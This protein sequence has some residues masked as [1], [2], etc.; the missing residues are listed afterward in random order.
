MFAELYEHFKD[1][2]LRQN[3]DGRYK[4]HSLHTSCAIIRLFGIINLSMGI[5]AL[6][7]YINLWTVNTSYSK[8]INKEI[9]LKKGKYNL[10]I[11]I[12]ELYQNN[13]H[14]TR[15][16]SY[17]QLAGKTKAINL[18]DTEPY[19]YKDGKPYYPAGLIAKTYFKDEIEIEKLKIK[20]EKISWAQDRKLI[21]ITKYTP[22]SIAYPDNWLPTTNRGTKALNTRDEKEMPILNE[23]FINW[24]RLS[25]Y[26]RFRK[27]WGRVEVPKSGKYRLKV[28]S[29]YGLSK[30]QL[31]FTEQCWLGYRNYPLVAG[32]LI[33]GMLGLILPKLLYS[34]QDRS[35]VTRYHGRDYTL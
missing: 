21:G 1:Q 14:Y 22:N 4:S 26:S 13:L 35:P 3:V 9:Y 18:K 32:L 15:S 24:I 7:S 6:I 34:Y 10:Y 28:E 19:D 2:I 17:E 30:K 33:I 8:S 29:V 11:E 12:D 16:I 23:R 27:L 25:A 31:V 5:T 20:T